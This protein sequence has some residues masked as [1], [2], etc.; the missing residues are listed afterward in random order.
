MSQS[1]GYKEDLV[2]SGQLESIGLKALHSILLQPTMFV[3]KQDIGHAFI[4][5]H[6]VNGKLGTANGID[7][8]QI[9]LGNGGFGAR[10]LFSSSV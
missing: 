1:Q 5:G 7:G 8:N 2:E 6:T 9:T 10:T 4:L 3:Y